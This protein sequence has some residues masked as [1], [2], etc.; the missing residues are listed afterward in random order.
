MLWKTH[1]IK[2]LQGGGVAQHG[3]WANLSL[4]DAIT[5][6]S[7]PRYLLFGSYLTLLLIFTVFGSVQ[8]QFKLLIFQI[9]HIGIMISWYQN[10][11]Q[12]VSY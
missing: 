8:K 2:A 5:T 10:L 9:V 6:L 11:G 4:N 3:K 12:S 1:A 7:K